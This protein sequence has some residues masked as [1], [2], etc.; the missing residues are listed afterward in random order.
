MAAFA[1]AERI[2]NESVSLLLSFASSESK[3]ARL[4]ILVLRLSRRSPTGPV[5]RISLRHV[6]KL[7]ALG[8]KVLADCDFPR[9]RP[10]TVSVWSMP[11]GT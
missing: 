11:D 7:S 8:E 3:R 5:R 1:F 9:S 6:S 10:V 2:A 4:F